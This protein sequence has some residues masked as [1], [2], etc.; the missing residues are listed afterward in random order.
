MIGR[1]FRSQLLPVATLLIVVLA[2]PLGSATSRSRMSSVKTV[3]LILFENTDWTSITPSVAPYIR[4][5]VLPM[6]AHATQY[7]NP[8]GTHP[9][10]PNYIWLE[11]GDD[12]G[13]ITDR[14]AG[15]SN[16][17]CSR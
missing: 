9:S 12:L 10:E 3:F 17:T 2:V 16:S 4:N 7:F 15:P 5:T 1:V 8:L 11:A 6:G 14:D 13:L